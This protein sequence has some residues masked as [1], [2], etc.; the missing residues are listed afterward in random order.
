M[1]LPDA[2]LFR[3]H[4][5]NARRPA[6]P[7]LGCFG[8]IFQNSET[9]DIGRIDGAQ[10]GEVGRNAINE[11]QWI[12]TASN[13]SGSPHTHTTESGHSVGAIGTYIHTCRLSVQCIQRIDNEAF[14]HPD[15]G[16]LVYR[17]QANGPRDRVLMQFNR[18]F[19]APRLN[20]K[21]NKE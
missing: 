21:G 10:R 19:L 11:Y 17:S 3:C 20:T 8:S 5:N 18:L 12:I 7:E 13:G 2:S 16:H 1:E 15:F 9:L 14:I 4:Y 6:R